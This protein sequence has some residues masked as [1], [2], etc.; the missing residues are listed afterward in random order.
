MITTYDSINRYIEH[1]LDDLE[2]IH[3][4]YKDEYIAALVRCTDQYAIIPTPTIP[5]LREKRQ[6]IL[7]GIGMLLARFLQP[8]LPTEGEGLQVPSSAWIGN[9]A[10]LDLLEAGRFIHVLR[11][12]GMERDGLV[13]S[14]EVGPDH[15]SI[16]KIIADTERF[17]RADEEWAVNKNRWKTNALRQDLD[18]K[19]K[20]RLNS[21]TILDYINFSSSGM[22]IKQF[23]SELFGLI[24][25]QASLTW[26]EYNESR[27]F[28]DHAIIASRTFGEWREICLTAATN[29]TMRLTYAAKARFEKISGAENLA[30]N[31]TQFVNDEYASGLFQAGPDDTRGFNTGDVHNAFYIDFDDAHRLC[32]EGEIP[33]P[34][35]IRWKNGLIIPIFGY[36]QNMSF[37][38]LNYLRSKYNDDWQAMVDLR[39]ASLQTELGKLFEGSEYKL[40]KWN[41]DIKTSLG[42]TDTDGAIYEPRSNCLYIFQLKSP[43]VWAGN[44]SQRRSR[45]RNLAGANKWIRKLC[46]WIE[47]T[48]KAQIASALGLDKAVLDID[49]MEIR[50]F[51]LCEFDTRI[52][53]AEDIFDRDAAWVSWPRLQRLILECNFPERALE[54]AYNECEKLDDV[55]HVLSGSVFEFK[56]LRVDL[57][58]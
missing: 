8:V 9:R 50:L 46:S 39:E 10:E 48:P 20:D 35:G 41:L 57:Y 21:I 19:V 4:T 18:K 42:P 23:D 29:L 1:W 12:A 30:K 51:V 55:Q 15:Y 32:S 16:S 58:E 3:A 11:I 36:L 43:D 14:E 44:L 26:S 5:F 22:E 49:T 53:T 7:A 34:Y 37:G 24:K 31:I 28:P 6:Y 17:E 56:N 25:E 54:Y 27:S 33:L 52:S 2:L 45:L 40:G 38:L 47:Q 13:R